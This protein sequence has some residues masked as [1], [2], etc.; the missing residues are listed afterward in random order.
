MTDYTTSPYYN[1][2]VNAAQTYG[3]PTNLFVAQIGQESGFNPSAVNGNA[4]GIAQFMPSTAQQFGINPADPVASL[5]AAAQYD[6]QLYN[7][8]GSWSAALS[9]YGTTANGNGPSVASLAKSID[10]GTT[11]TPTPAASGGTAPSFGFLSFVSDLPRLATVI[12][13]LV[14]IVIGL[15]QLGAKPAVKIVEGAKGLAA[16]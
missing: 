8:L 6:S 7:Q 9:A 1:A 11:P 2:A 4:Y 12:I 14:L 5:N 15:A 13:G 16:A 10:A 3:V